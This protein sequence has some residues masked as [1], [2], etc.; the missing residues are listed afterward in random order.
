MSVLRALAVCA[1]LVAAL[2]ACVAPT[3]EAGGGAP[4]VAR[5]DPTLG[6][7]CKVGRDGGPLL[8]ERGI[9]GTGAQAGAQTGPQAGRL[10]LADRGIGGTGVQLGDLNGPTRGVRPT[11]TVT[12]AQPRTTGVVGVITGFASICLDGLEI[13]F[14]HTGVI[15]IEGEVA[16]GHALRAGQVAVIEATGAPDAL[17]ART[18]AV[19]H[20]VSGQIERLEVGGNAMVV[21]GQ[22]VTVPPTAWGAGRHGL[23]DWIAVSGLRAPDGSIVATRLDRGREDGVRIRGQVSADG[24][25]LRI[26]SMA[27]RLPTGSS[28]AAGQ[29]VSVT[30]SYQDGALQVG[31]VAQDVLAS[32]PPAYFGAGVGRVLV[33]SI[34]RVEQGRVL[35]NG[36]VRLPASAAVSARRGER[37]NAVVSFEKDADGAYSAT[38]VREVD[39]STAL[40]A[41]G[42]SLN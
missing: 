10:K 16:D 6:G 33:Q 42:S 3:P 14:D 11:E 5:D 27:L 2:P 41:L 7:L 15:D 30:G 39:G 8:A 38:G 18:V 1:A 24:G 26:G 19:R 35:I 21:A 22:R 31:K 17:R 9:G 25:T 40:P 13:A 34:V 37:G 32:N 20:E 36:Q 28:V 29:F 12:T 4:V 23:G